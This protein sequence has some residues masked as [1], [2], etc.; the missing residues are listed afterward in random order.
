MSDDIHQTILA[1][2]RTRAP[3]K[4]KYT[5]KRSVKL[6]KAQVTSSDKADRY[7]RAARFE[8]ALS[9]MVGD[10]VSGE[11]RRVFY[12]LERYLTSQ[13]RED[14]SYVEIVLSGWLYLLREGTMHDSSMANDREPAVMSAAVICWMDA[15][16][17]WPDT[18]E[19]LIHQLGVRA[20]AIREA[21]SALSARVQ[22]VEPDALRAAIMTTYHEA[23]SEP[24]EQE[25]TA[26]PELPAQLHTLDLDVFRGDGPLSK[27]L[28]AQALELH[29]TIEAAVQDGLST[30]LPEELF[31][32]FERLS[33]AKIIAPLSD[34][35][36][37]L[38]E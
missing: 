30:P 14:R 18:S 7:S 38:K 25:L 22:G 34:A 11:H 24:D 5:P 32:F 10:D 35:A 2:R 13:R 36:R 33:D 37:S 8:R 19:R 9:R 15:L 6:Q 16:F 28:L 31:R 21:Y 29:A 3:K 1:N 26:P 4:Q 20:S 12:V 23:L 27:L 17:G